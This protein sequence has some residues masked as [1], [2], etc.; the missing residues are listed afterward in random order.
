M[1]ELPPLNGKC[2]FLGKLQANNIIN[3]N[4]TV[5]GHQKWNTSQRQINMKWRKSG[6]D[7][8]CFS[9]KEIHKKE[10][11]W[12]IFV[13]RW[14]SNW[15]AEEVKIIVEW[16]KRGDDFKYG[17]KRLRKNMMIKT[18]TEGCLKIKVASKT[19]WIVET[20]FWCHPGWRNKR[21]LNEHRPMRHYRAKGKGPEE[22]QKRTR[23]H[24]ILNQIICWIYV[25]V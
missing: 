8:T 2:Y 24:R 16:W 9:L 5:Y 1:S 11:K 17:Q 7:Y 14:K 13:F 15:A 6:V 4:C 12:N 21:L 22:T 3:K 20:V 19:F 23:Y 10:R 25:L 18:W